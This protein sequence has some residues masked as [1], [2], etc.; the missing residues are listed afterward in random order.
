MATVAGG[1]PLPLGS[2]K[3]YRPDISNS[4]IKRILLRSETLRRLNSVGRLTLS[5]SRTPN[6]SRMIAAAFGDQSTA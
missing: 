3:H 5:H 4:P 1:L 2:L 6:S